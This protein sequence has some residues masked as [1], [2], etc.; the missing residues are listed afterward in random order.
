M[1][2]RQTTEDFVVDLCLQVDPRGVDV[3]RLSRQLQL[4][5]AAVAR[6]TAGARVWLT[7]V[8]NAATQAEAVHRSRVLIEAQLAE[9]AE[10]ALV[11][12]IDCVAL[13]DL[14]A[15]LDPARD[16]PELTTLELVELLEDTMWSERPAGVGSLTSF[17]AGPA[18]VATPA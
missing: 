7:A 5:T 11:A 8:I 3:E 4:P 9:W 12:R 18:L 10:Q 6:A 13:G 2:P 1:A 17:E 15:W 14:Y 16:D